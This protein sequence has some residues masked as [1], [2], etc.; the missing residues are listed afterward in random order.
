LSSGIAAIAAGQYQTCALT[1]S[2]GVQCWGENDSGQLGNGST[3]D[4]HVPV[5][6]V[7][8]S[9]GVAAIS[10]GFSEACAVTTTG[11]ALCWGDNYVGGLGDNST[12]NSSVPVAVSGSST[13]ISSIAV[14]NG[15]ACAL[16]TAGNITCWGYGIYD[17]L[18]NGSAMNSPVPVNVV[19]P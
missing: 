13:G 17:Q 18:G 15:S 10:V 2:G 3:V 12:T 8:L 6:V 14:G 1:T 4:S 9:T 5:G 19:E 11:G 7:G 16:A